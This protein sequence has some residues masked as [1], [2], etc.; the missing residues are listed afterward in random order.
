[1]ILSLVRRKEERA[2]TIALGFHC[3][4]SDIIQTCVS[5]FACGCMCV[6]FPSF[7]VSSLRWPR[8]ARIEGTPFRGTP[9]SGASPFTY[10]DFNMFCR[11]SSIFLF[12]CFTHQSL[13]SVF[14]F[15]L[16]TF[17]NTQRIKSLSQENVST[18]PNSCFSLQ[19]L[20][21]IYVKKKIITIHIIIII[22]IKQKKKTAYTCLEFVHHL[23]IAHLC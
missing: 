11:F 19:E 22:K 12:S 18:T 1:M 8:V 13:V 20:R 10:N 21:K 9:F 2:Y 16:F 23:F 7:L 5:V 3:I 14:L 17:Y 4:N 6:S 15:L